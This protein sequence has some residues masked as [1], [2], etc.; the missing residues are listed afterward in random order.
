MFLRFQT[1]LKGSKACYR[2]LT[3]KSLVRNADYP[4]KWT[5]LFAA[6][7]LGDLPSIENHSN[8]VDIP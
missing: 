2:S 5:F 3:A 8:E 7:C 4:D 6:E 1:T